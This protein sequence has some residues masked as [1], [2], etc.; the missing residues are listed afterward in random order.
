MKPR[1][2]HPHLPSAQGA[3]PL[4]TS[5]ERV[6]FLT[7]HHNDACINLS[8]AKRSHRCMHVQ[9]ILA[10]RAGRRGHTHNS[11]CCETR[12]LV[13]ACMHAFALSP[14]H[15]SHLQSE[16]AQHLLTRTHCLHDDHS[17]A[18]RGSCPL[19]CNLAKLAERA[20]RCKQSP[21]C[22]RCVL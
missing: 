17:P 8:T 14:Q 2:L 1:T 3:A 11:R 22:S 4:L 16:G 7:N 20:L 9:L 5:A 15:I 10:A 21:T 6:F 12:T 19:P 13:H 18:K